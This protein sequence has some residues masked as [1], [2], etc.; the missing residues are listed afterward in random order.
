[1]QDAVRAPLR[2]EDALVWPP[3]DP[4]RRADGAVGGQICHVQLGTVPGH[5]GVVPA[6]PRQPPPVGA[7]AWKRV[8]VRARHDRSRGGAPVRGQNDDL[9]DRFPGLGVPLPHA[10]DQLSIRCHARVGVPV[11]GREFRRGCD[12]SRVLTRALPVETL[13]VEVGEEHGLPVHHERAAPVLVHA[14]PHVEPFGRDV[15]SSSVRC[16]PN[17]NRPSCLRGTAFQPVHVTVRKVRSSEP[18]AGL[19]D[20]LRCDGRLPRSVLR[21]PAFAQCTTP[22]PVGASFVPR[23]YQSSRQKAGQTEGRV[24]FRADPAREI[25]IELEPYCATNVASS[26]PLTSTV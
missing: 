25:G 20:Q 7:D 1:M 4:L 15:G 23:R 11:A 9:V 5:V 12:G 8:E 17:Q 22:S 6:D 10:Y 24:R 21:R 26:V 19:G 13:V 3:G 16:L 18:D 14:S 2:L